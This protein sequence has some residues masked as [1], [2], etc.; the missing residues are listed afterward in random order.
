MNQPVPPALRELYEKMYKERVA[1]LR[2][3][4][5]FTD[6]Q[7][8][9]PANGG[10][11]LK[12]ALAHLA[13]AERGWRDWGLGIRNQLGV[14]FG[15]EDPQAQPFEYTLEATNR[16]SLRHWIT[17]LK[18]VRAE[19]LRVLQEAGLTEEDLQ[20]RGRHRGFGEMSV[21]QALRS[22][23]RHDRMHLDQAMGREP[24]YQPG[25]KPQSE[26]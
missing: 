26:G 10:W 23:Y 11:S 1:L 6:E 21:V 13:D 12:Q 14:E 16:Q 4:R 7:A 22:L 17:R 5:T 25:K 8:D 20:R 3:L 2:A 15:P 9:Q 19:T 18:A 24:A